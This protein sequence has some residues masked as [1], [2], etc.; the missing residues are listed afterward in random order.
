MTFD[1]WWDK[2]I[3]DSENPYT[4][5]SPI[6][7]AFAGW[8]ARGGEVNHWKDLAEYRLALLTKMPEDNTWVGLT[9][10]EIYALD[11]EM[12]LDA[13]A[14]CRAVEAKLKEKNT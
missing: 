9:D 14:L 4:K 12:R 7:W 10:E 3:D 1:E 2:E 5:D 6:Y 13:Y 8:Q 11:D